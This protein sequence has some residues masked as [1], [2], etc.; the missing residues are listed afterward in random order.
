MTKKRLKQLSWLR[1]EIEDISKRIQM[2]ERVLGGRKH[3]ADS[4]KWLQNETEPQETQLAEL[5]KQMEGR[6]SAALQECL[7]LQRYI[8]TIEDSQTRTIFTLRYFEGLSWHQVAWRL[9]G[10]TSDSVRM[11]HNRYLARRKDD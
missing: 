3:H 11:I 1:L 2:F 5:L 9:G 8:E 7:A 6:Q 4:L 10:N